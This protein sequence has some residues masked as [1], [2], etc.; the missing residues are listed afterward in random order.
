MIATPPIPARRGLPRFG[1]RSRARRR[2]PA[3]IVALWT[4]IA[5]TL[6]VGSMA[7]DMRVEAQI[8]SHYRKRVKGQA[9]AQAGIE[10]AKMILVQS[11]EVDPT[12]PDTMDEDPT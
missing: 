3:L 7:F 1:S 9:L 5:L 8:T 6:L 10:W 11:R 4:L 12:A 2:G